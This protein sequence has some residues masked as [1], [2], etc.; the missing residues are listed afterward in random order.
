MQGRFAERLGWS[1][2]SRDHKAAEDFSFDN[3]YAPP[4]ECSKLRCT[5]PS[6]TTT[7]DN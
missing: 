1:A 6:R 5:L 7:Y 4:G 3:Q 2:A